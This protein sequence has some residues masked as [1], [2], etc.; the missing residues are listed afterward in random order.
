MGD[1]STFQLQT[2]RSLFDAKETELKDSI[3][4]LQIGEVKEVNKFTATVKRI[5][6]EILLTP[7]KIGKPKITAHEQVT[8]PVP[9]Q[10]QGMWG[11][12]RTVNVIKVQFPYTGSRELFDYRTGESLAM[13]TIYEPSGGTI[14]VDVELQ[15]LDKAAA[16]SKAKE[17]MAI[18]FKLI[19]QNNSDAEQWSAIQTPLIE[20]MADKKR[21]ELLDFY[22]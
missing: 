14:T 2:I 10:Y 5:K 11:R 21:K 1:K 13:G 15:Q 16:I 19:E 9:Q 12:S 7:V 4:N 8:K 18:T 20:Q 6:R 22:S 17:E 3:G